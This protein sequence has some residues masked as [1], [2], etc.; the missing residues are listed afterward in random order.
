MFNNT[1]IYLGVLILLF[2]CTKQLDISEFSDDFDNY[3]PE[4][5]IEALILP[6][7]N[8]AIVRVDRSVLINDTEV[9][10]CKDDDF[11]QISENECIILGGTWHGNSD[12]LIADCGDWDPILHDL[13]QDG[14]EGDPQ[15][16]DEDCEDCSFTDSACQETCREED[17]IGENNGIPDCGEPNVDETDEIIKDVHINNCSIKIIN[18]NSECTFVYDKNA[19]SFFYNANFGK[20]DSTFIVDNIETPN[21]GAYIPSESCSEF[22]W[23]DY[24]AD[25]SFE[26]ECPNYGTII[27][28]APIQ[29]PTPVVFHNESDVLSESRDT[30]EFTS[31]ISLC[32][33]NECLK[34][35][36]SIWNNDNQNYDIMYFGRYGFNDF[37]Y[38]SS[39]NPY[40]YYQSVQYF[41]DKN[42]NRY[43]YYHG[44]P[45]GATEVENI[46]GNAAFMGEA[47]VTDLLDE[48]SDLDP[49]DKY[50][51]EM[52]TFSEEYK[53]YYFFDLL[54]LRDPVR[55]NLRKLD[56]SG[57][58]VAPIMGAFGAMNSQKIYFEIIDCFQYV[59][60]Q[61]CENINNVK[62]VCQWYDENNSFGD[63]NKNGQQ[64]DG[65]NTIPSTLFNRCGPIKMPPIEF[66]N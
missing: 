12:D 63:I 6:A 29:L 43:L 35:Y 26:C 42:N 2:S 34:N 21:Y 65:E 45:D 30:E 47:V 55:S 49:I 16:D 57:N 32:L 64:D 60:Q 33:D 15:D 62:S 20:D 36:S 23:A 28:K 51:Y 25:Y 8:T 50:Y 31:S 11:G 14:V 22:N 41:Y 3:S 56:E 44:H 24:S 53:N 13:G 5:R 4:L 59:D 37:I 52:F 9:Y 54:D 7:D 66:I 61:S 58:P 48:F 18:Q 46:H 27:S 10:N 39:I 19:G 17:S 40:Y 1:K 38:Y